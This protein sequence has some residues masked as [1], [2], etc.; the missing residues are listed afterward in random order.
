MSRLPRRSILRLAS[1]LPVSLAG[2]SAN[3]DAAQ[4]SP[5]STSP[6]SSESSNDA[7]PSR[8]PDI[9]TALTSGLVLA[10]GPSTAEPLGVYDASP[11]F[12]AAVNRA[13]NQLTD[14][15]T[16]LLPPGRY[17]GT[18]SIRPSNSGVQISG[19]GWGANNR[20]GSV[21]E[22]IGTEYLYEGSGHGFDISELKTGIMGCSLRNLKLRDAGGEGTHGM[23]LTNPTPDIGKIQGWRFEEV[24]VTGFGGDCWH[25]NTAT[26]NSILHGI[27]GYDAGGNGITTRGSTSVLHLIGQFVNNGHWGAEIGAAASLDVSIRCDA[28]GQRD[29]SKGGVYLGSTSGQYNL[30]C[31][32]NRGPGLV[33]ESSA[34]GVVALDLIANNQA[35][36]EQFDLVVQDANELEIGGRLELDAHRRAVT[37]RDAARVHFGPLEVSGGTDPIYD[38]AGRDVSFA[39]SPLRGLTYNEVRGEACDAAGQIA[40]TFDGTYTRR[41]AVIVTVLSVTGE[42]PNSWL[43]Q[44]QVS[45]TRGPD[46]TFDGVDV[47]F[48][49]T[50][51]TT[52][53]RGDVSADVMVQPR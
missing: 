39:G 21:T 6:D 34:S 44:P 8:A 36:E 48:R 4:N 19:T 35:G 40:F 42:P 29:S 9:L 22:S 30:W 23:Y 15:G 27:Y 17:P 11:D 31:E 14:G 13:W 16:I 53:T 12:G 51:G 43:A 50:D 32:R 20:D 7:Q 33:V 2:C 46:E 38:I 10:I 26:F 5:T 47:Q 37:V 28:N 24:F 1:V 41:P 49:W 18:T 25:I 3:N 45:V 52:P